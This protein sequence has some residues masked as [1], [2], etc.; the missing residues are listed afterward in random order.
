MSVD[1]VWPCGAV[2]RPISAGQIFGH[3][4]FVGSGL[5]DEVEKLVDA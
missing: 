5:E 2:F 4:K 1:N 3:R